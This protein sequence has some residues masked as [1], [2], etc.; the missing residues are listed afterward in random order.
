MK[1]LTQTQQNILDG[2]KEKIKK[3]K[4]HET[5]ESY[6]LAN[7][8]NKSQWQIEMELKEQSYK[9]Y[10]LQNLD[11]IALT[12]CSSS[13]LRALENKGYIKIIKDGGRFIDTVKLLEEK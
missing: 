6:V 13:S 8:D 4:A 12:S 2:I 3:A 10:W 9:E 11:N 7:Y 1:K 5:Y